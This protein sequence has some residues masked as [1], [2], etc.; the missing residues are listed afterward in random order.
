MKRPAAVLTLDDLRLLAEL[1]RERP[2]SHA[3]SARLLGINRARL[4]RL[5]LRVNAHLGEE[6]AWRSGSRFSLPTEVVRIAGAF[7]RFE[8]ALEDVSGSPL[9]S[10]GSSAS[11]LFLRL[12]S[13]DSTHFSGRIVSLRSDRVVEALSN[14]SLDLALV[15]DRSACLSRCRP[16]NG[17]GSEQSV[18]DGLIARTLLEW[19]VHAITPVSPVR[20]GIIHM[21]EWEE[22]SSGAALQA[23]L[24]PLPHETPYPR[25][26]CASFLQA[27]ELVRRGLVCRAAVPSIYL[28]SCEPALSQQQLEPLSSGYLVAIRRKSDGQRWMAYLDPT[29][30]KNVIDLERDAAPEIRSAG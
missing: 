4:T 18:G 23:L 12:L 10:A 20:R 27:V 3:A 22:G 25:L 24:T 29:K 14:H 26:R 6:L 13:A 28:R 8:R 7:E 16:F 1:A 17:I 9:I 19:R 2:D 30:W 5:M 15:S 11:M 21:L